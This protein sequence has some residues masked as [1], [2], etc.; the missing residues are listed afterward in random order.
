[1][2]LLLLIEM[3]SVLLKRGIY[4]MLTTFTFLNIYLVILMKFSHSEKVALYIFFE[5]Q[6]QFSGNR[7]NFQIYAFK[8]KEKG[9]NADLKS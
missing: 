7:L 1:M 9:E 4:R 2:T 8:E 5:S 3:K 6:N